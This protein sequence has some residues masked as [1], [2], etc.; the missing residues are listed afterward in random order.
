MIKNS[1][2]KLVEKISSITKL[3]NKKSLEYL[4]LITVLGIIILL[5][6]NGLWGGEKKETQKVIDVTRQGISHD[7]DQPNY[8]LEQRIAKILSEI[9]GVGRVSV[10]ITYASGPEVVPARDSKY[11]H[12]DTNERDSGG[13]ERSVL[14]KDQDDKLVLVEEQSGV[15]KPLILKQLAPRVMGV[16]VVADG[17]NDITVKT[18][19]VRAVESAAGVPGHRVQVFK[20]H[21]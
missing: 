8:G 18:N 21:S 7:T 12:S 3:N 14:Q 4:V 9:Q 13:G 19:I 1:I 5:T 16:V 6:A 17:A 11:N 10:L 2:N 20:R 15:K